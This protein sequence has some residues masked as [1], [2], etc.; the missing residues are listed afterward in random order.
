M[1]KYNRGGKGGDKLPF[2]DYKFIDTENQTNKMTR[3]N[4][5]KQTNKKNASLVQKRFEI[6]RCPKVLSTHNLHKTVLSTE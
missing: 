4:L 6:K 3:M 1:L 2:S 5:L